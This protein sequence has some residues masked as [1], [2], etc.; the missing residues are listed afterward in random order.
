MLG[1]LPN[2]STKFW[3]QTDSECLKNRAKLCRE[4]GLSEP[5]NSSAKNGRGVKLNVQTSVQET[6]DRYL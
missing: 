4:P 1:F 5:W 2:V 3:S 6:L